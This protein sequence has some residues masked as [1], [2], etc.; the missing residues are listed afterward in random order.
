MVQF[1][2]EDGSHSFVQFISISIY[3]YSCNSRISLIYQTYSNIKH[4]L[5]ESSRAY[6]E[7]DQ[8]FRSGYKFKFVTKL[9]S[10]GRQWWWQQHWWRWGC[11][12]VII[13][14]PGQDW[15]LVGL[16]VAQISMHFLVFL[17]S[18]K[19]KTKTVLTTN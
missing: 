14:P 19:R 15:Y 18:E 4:R 12:I 11:F 7:E 5:Q 9:G 8:G 3:F 16:C 10:P 1:L 17:V 13:K 6:C 2:G